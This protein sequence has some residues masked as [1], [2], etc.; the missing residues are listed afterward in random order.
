MTDTFYSGYF[1][2]YKVLTITD[3]IN[4]GY[5][6]SYKIVTMTDTINFGYF[7]SYK[8]VTM[9]DT[10]DFVHLEAFLKHNC[11]LQAHCDY[12]CYTDTDVEFLSHFPYQ[13]QRSS[14][15]AYEETMC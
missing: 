15:E 5:F 4:S 1:R 11:Y 10:L 6:G 3:T 9:T 7:G 12:Y 13:W 2:F 8:I 14:T